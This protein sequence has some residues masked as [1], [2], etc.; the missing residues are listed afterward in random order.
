[1]P[2]PTVAVRVDWNDDADYADTGEDVSARVLHNP[3]IAI[4]RG[5]DQIRAL[6]PPMAGAA[7]FD[8]NNASKDYSP[9]NASSPIYSRLYPGHLVNIRATHNAVTSDLFTGYLD[10]LAQH[11]IARWG[12]VSAPCLGPLSKLKGVTVSTGLYTTITTDVALGYLLDAAGW[13]AGAS[14]RT[15]DTGKTT[16]L[17]WWCDED[18]AFDMA[19]TLLNTEGPGATLYED[20]AGR[21]VFESRHYRLLTS[22]C[23]TSQVTFGAS[24]T[25]PKHAPPLDYN[26]QIQ[27]IINRAIV[28]V[29]QR[30]YQALAPVWQLNATLSIGTNQTQQFVVTGTDPFDSAVC[31]N[32]T[33]Y[34]VSAGSLTSVTLSRTSGANLT[35]TLVAGASGATVT[36][37]QVRA[38]AHTATAT[39]VAETVDTTTSR[40][41][42]GIRTYTD[43]LWPEVNANVAQDFANAIVS[44]YQQPR[45]TVSVR[46][47]NAHTTRLTHMLTRQISDRVTV[48]ETQTGLN[49]EMFI[50]QVA[51]SIRAGGR[52]MVTV[53]G[54]EKA[55]ET[56][57]TFVLDSS[58]AGVLDSN[59]LGY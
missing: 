59:A 23:L 56:V 49:T 32:A 26:P 45:P 20:G 51:H 55:L 8:L 40:A 46:V 58:S 54:C 25:E 2:T 18:D 21:I 57:G 14:Y 16:L 37:L 29:N 13:P 7:T 31:V 43:P 1:M 15:L 48:I 3:G 6:A 10:D 44:F 11:P 41:R 12:S 39:K 53:F 9:E 19:V 4:E 34:T 5:R 38:Q 42:Y 52:D 35:L 47:N 27:N 50:E 33:D 24:T 36:G 28:T 30:T 22:R 17:Y